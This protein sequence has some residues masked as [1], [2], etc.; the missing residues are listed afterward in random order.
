[1]IHPLLHEIMQTDFF[2]YF[3]LNI[4]TKCPFWNDDSVCYKE[5]CSIIACQDVLITKGWSKQSDLPEYIKNENSDPHES[6]DHSCEM[7]Q[8]NNITRQGMNEAFHDW[9]VYDDNLVNFCYDNGFDKN[10]KYFDLIANPEKFT[11][12]SG[13]SAGR[14]WMAIYK[15]NCFSPNIDEF[16]RIVYF[17]NY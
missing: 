10:S 3:N 17:I 8:I 14:I 16:K 9:E 6:V 4:S 13:K 1:M 5:D 15:E 12:Y 11:G 7:G 2:R